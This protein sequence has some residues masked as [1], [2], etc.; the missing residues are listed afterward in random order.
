[1]WFQNRRAKCRKHESQH[2]RGGGGCGGGAAAGPAANG[3]GPDLSSP[4]PASSSSSSS[5][6]STSSCSS[7]SAPI[8][9]TRLA[10]AGLLRLKSP[11]ATVVLK[12]HHHHHQQQQQQQH[13]GGNCGRLS[14]SMSAGRRRQSPPLSNP[15]TAN[16]A[17][18]TDRLKEHVLRV[19]TAQPPPTTA[20]TGAK[21]FLTPHQVGLL[22]YIQVY[23]FCILAELRLCTTS[24]KQSKADKPSKL[25]NK[26]DGF[27]GFQCQP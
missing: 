8:A 15:P 12:Q 18:F 20:Q 16:A 24:I 3:N 13:L 6:S 14:P 11:S 19:M 5:S 4:P 17:A 27:S 9:S 2:Y 25:I 26:G 1:M 10:A 23:L 7:S 21:S 22:S